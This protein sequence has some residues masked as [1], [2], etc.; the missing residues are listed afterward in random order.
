M[1]NSQKLEEIAENL[2]CD[3]RESYS[4]RGMYGKSCVGID[5]DSYNEMEG[6]IEKALEHGIKGAKTDSMGKGYIVYWPSISN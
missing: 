1:T 5:V 4:G 3:F 2:G 6:V